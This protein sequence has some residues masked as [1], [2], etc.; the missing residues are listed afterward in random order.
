MPVS[1]LDR[2]GGHSFFLAM[3]L[4]PGVQHK[5]QAGIDRDIGN[6]RFPTLEDQSSLPYLDALM[7]E[8]FRWNPVGPSGKST[9]GRCPPSF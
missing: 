3:T 6:D 2:I 4:H 7:K 8:V 1:L 9:A 5:A